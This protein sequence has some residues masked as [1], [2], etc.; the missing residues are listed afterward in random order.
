MKQIPKRVLG[1]MAAVALVTASAARAEALLSLIEKGGRDT[2]SANRT[3]PFVELRDTAGR[4]REY[5]VPYIPDQNARNVAADFVA[6]WKTYQ[7][8]IHWAMMV[9]LNNNVT[10]LGTPHDLRFMNCT[11][12]LPADLTIA[13]G[14]ALTGSTWVKADPGKIELKP[15]NPSSEQARKLPSGGMN[16]WRDD[17]VKL[18]NYDV[19][20]VDRGRYCGYS[21]NTLIPDELTTYVPGVRVCTIF[22]CVATP[23]YPQPI[24]ISWGT[25][26]AR[27]RA[28]CDAAN[29]GETADYQK[30]NLASL[31]K[32]APLAIH[33]NGVES[34]AGMRSGTTMAPF[35]TLGSNL[36]SVANIAKTDA[37]FPVYLSGRL[38]LD[39]TTLLSNGK[40]GVPDLE[41]LKRYLEPGNLEEQEAQGEA[42]FLQAWQQLDTLNDVRPLRYW[43]KAMQCTLLSCIPTP[44]MLLAPSV[45]V[46]P[47]SC[48][49][50]STVVRTGS[51]NLNQYRYRWGVVSVPEGYTVPNVVG[52][53]VLRTDKE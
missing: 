20:R 29:R 2:A 28:V 7:D 26:A 46:T 36:D 51:T 22:G 34:V 13:A 11:L 10:A 18:E 39:A 25:L 23:K 24:S 31:A 17:G 49:V 16:G 5:S 32:N 38:P 4:E 40:T 42:A 19:P 6:N 21:S 35:Y 1:L 30:Q 12:Q 45:F 3:L 33:W 53:P 52:S 15:S 8:T 48:N 47:A 9:G 41:V 44:V 37:R 14:Q 43:A 50:P 27:L